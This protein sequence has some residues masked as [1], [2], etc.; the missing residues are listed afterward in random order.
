M[1]DALEARLRRALGADPG[2]QVRGEA[3]GAQHAEGRHGRTAALVLAATAQRKQLS[4]CSAAPCARALRLCAH[5]GMASLYAV[6][7]ATQGARRAGGV[8]RECTHVPGCS[9][10]SWLSEQQ[11][12]RAAREGARDARWGRAALCKGAHGAVDPLCDSV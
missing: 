3:R 2:A 9:P 10:A 5:G 8:A 7:A 6:R 11:L 12:A 4:L 1:G